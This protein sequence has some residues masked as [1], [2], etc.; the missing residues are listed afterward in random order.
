[1]SEKY[2]LSYL[3]AIQRCLD[4]KGFIRGDG[5]TNGMY[6]KKEDGLLIIVNGK[7]HHRK[8]MDLYIHQNLLGQKWKLFSVANSKALT[9]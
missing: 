3:E 9:N 4:G 7:D 1:M 6:V 2:N 5:M 8:H